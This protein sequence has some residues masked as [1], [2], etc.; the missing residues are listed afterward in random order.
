MESIHGIDVSW[1][2]NTHNKGEHNLEIG[3]GYAEAFSVA[4]AGPESP[5]RH[6]PIHN[7]LKMLLLTLLSEIDHSRYPKINSTPPENTAPPTQN[8]TKSPQI[9]AKSV[10][11]GEVQQSKEVPSTPPA[12]TSQRPAFIRRESSEKTLTIPKSGTPSQGT[13]RRNSWLSSISSKFSSPGAQNHQ[14][15]GTPPVAAQPKVPDEQTFRTPQWTPPK[16]AVLP[17]GTKPQGNAPYTPAPT[18]PTQSNF[19]SSALRRLSSSSGGQLS[20][21]GKMPHYGLCE[22]KILNVDTHRERPL[23]PEL[24]QSKLRRVSFCVDVEIAGGP[25]YMDED[26]DKEKEEKK[27]KKKLVERGEGEALKHPEAVKEEKENDEVVKAAG[28]KL[29]KEPEQEAADTS[30]DDPADE[31]ADGPADKDK[32]TSKKKEK[33][34]RSEEE[35]KARKEKK[36]KLAEANGTLPVELVMNG[37]DSSLGDETPTTIPGT[38]K[39]QAAPTTDPARIYRRCCQLREAPILKKITEQL[40][41]PLNSSID[42]PGAVMKLD[43]SG[44]WLQLPDL[45]TLADYLAVVPIKELVMENCSLTDEGVRVLL[46]G[47]LAAKYQDT[48]ARRKHRADRASLLVHQGGVVERVV[49][50]NNPKIGRDGWGHIALFIHLC[51]SIKNMD[52]SMIPF[53]QSVSTANDAATPRPADTID[54]FTKAI[55]ERLGGP[56]LELL[57]M[58]ETGLTTVQ[59]GMLIDAVNKSGLRRLGLAGNRITAEGMQHVGRYLKRGKCEG[60]DLG[61]ID[62]KDHLGVIANS[63]DENHPLWALSLANCSLSPDSLWKLFPVLAKLKNFRFIDLS[64]NHDLFLANPSALSL[65]RR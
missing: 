16:I 57:N 9:S 22:R 64:H 12:Q 53:P 47:L 58:A 17:H 36:R 50:K 2:H 30:T 49:F 42:K 48:S 6:W 41:S 27:Q 37:S 26:D 33:K 8:G 1:I 46:A 31:P 61:G 44:Y 21:P 62:M 59:L 38:P 39:T 4:V 7:K 56:E 11:N 52:L 54:I 24:D 20:G 13:G 19:L 18:K 45:V 63:L 34:K 28:E 51:R 29:P 60:L 25:R 15:N 55:S 3:A 35:R 43:L 14:H 32:D 40:S 10:Q 65:F 5:L 23:I